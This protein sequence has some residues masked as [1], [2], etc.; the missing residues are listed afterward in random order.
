MSPAL[1]E[2]RA[3]VGREKRLRIHTHSLHQIGL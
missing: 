2:R 3:R 1:A